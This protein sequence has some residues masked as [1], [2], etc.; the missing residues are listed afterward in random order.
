[1]RDGMRL[2]ATVL[3]LVAGLS[4]SACG[5]DPAPRPP[6]VLAAASTQEAMTEAAEA[7]AAQGHLK[8]TLSFAG[9]GALA[10]Q[11]AT[12]A[13]A[14][15]FVSADSRWMDWV[16]ANVS[17]RHG[18]RDIVATNTLVLIAPKDSDAAFPEGGDWA[19]ALDGGRLAIADPVAVPAGRYGKASLISIGAW[20]EVKDHVAQT[21]D[22]RA[23]LA[24]VSRG[25]A[26]LGIVY[27]SD[28]IADEGVKVVGRFPDE[29]HAPITYPIAIP[30]RST[31][32]DAEGFRKFLLSPEGQSI[33]EK[34][35][36]GPP[37]LSGE[38]HEAGD[39]AS[40]DEE[41]EA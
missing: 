28:A 4:L 31:A 2:L 38:P 37:P 29:S 36:F 33:F 5:K 15:L 9:S 17:L 19:K 8:P 25:D 12:G 6:L 7:W 32:T 24:L 40:G 26:P 10:R 13:P 21:A 23:A 1:M 11:I 16:E 34:Y 30:D 39:A 14:D 27:G 41:P 20:D 35:G 22:V 3:A 18:T